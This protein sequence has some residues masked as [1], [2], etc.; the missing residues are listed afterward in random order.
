VRFDV[1]SDLNWILAEGSG[2]GFESS[3]R[4]LGMVDDW[5]RPL[6]GI[7]EHVDGIGGNHAGAN[8]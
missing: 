6:V 2:E 5:H 7:S 3:R 8:E 1:L 4:Q